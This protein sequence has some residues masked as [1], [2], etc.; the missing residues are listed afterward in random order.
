MKKL[1]VGCGNNPLEGYKNID[2]YY[3][4]GCGRPDLAQLTGYDWSYGDAVSLQDYN[5]TF[6]EV[7]MVHT[8][9]HLSMDDG[10][11]AIQQA[12]RV[13]KPGGVLEIEVPNLTTACELFLRTSPE[14]PKWLRIMGLLYGTTGV[15]GEGQFHLTGYTKDRLKQKMEE[16]NI[17]NIE[18]IPV[19]FGH[20]AAEPQY[21]FRLKGIKK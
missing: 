4:P 7:I 18:E 17:I 11:R 16:H 6:D 12:V 20:G 19:G 2:K 3:Y 21:D 10:N 14:D 15:D 1:N 8:L 5:D 9:E 13:L